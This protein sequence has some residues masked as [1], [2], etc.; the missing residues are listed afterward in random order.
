MENFRVQDEWLDDKPKLMRVVFGD[1][2]HQMLIS[3]GRGWAPLLEISAQVLGN[4]A[5]QN[6]QHLLAAFLFGDAAEHN[7]DARI[8]RIFLS[9]L[10]EPQ[11]LAKK[12]ER[13]IVGMAYGILYTSDKNPAWRFPLIRRLLP[14]AY[15]TQ[16]DGELPWFSQ[17]D[18][19]NIAEQAALSRN[20][21]HADRIELIL[22]RV[23]Q[24]GFFRRLAPPADPRLLESLAE[25]FP[26]FAPVA[27]HYAAQAAIATLGNG[28]L[29][30]APVLLLGEPG[31]GKTVF[32]V[33]LAE[34]LGVRN[35]AISFSHATQ[36]GQLGGLSAF[37]G[38]GRQGHVFNALLLGQ[39]LNPVFVLDEVDKAADE[40]KYQPLG[41]LYSLLEVESAAQFRDEFAEFAV[42]ASWFSWVATA[43]ELECLP[44]P[45][46]SRLVVFDVR[47][48]T[49]S[50]LRQI[51]RKQY[52]R[53]IEKYGLSAHLPV[54]PPPALLDHAAASPRELRL[55]LQTAIGRMA[56]DRLAGREFRFEVAPKKEPERGRIGFL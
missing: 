37:W 52:Q 12:A 39:E 11:T 41:A 30:M 43:N 20:S 4:P 40:S 8:E 2:S 29:R 53:L 48:P 17:D 28:R 31:I 27:E 33:R 16:H 51:G 45:I 49:M 22:Q 42:D 18:W 25:E 19:A 9:L 55:A 26:N 5:D 36:G 23:P 14:Y 35:Y 56:R 46:K 10:K 54:E 38:N 1:C 13:T 7:F 6:L 21:D 44:E 50:E 32:A 47:R 24:S 15:P 3:K 34:Q